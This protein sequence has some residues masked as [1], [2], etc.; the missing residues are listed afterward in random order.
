MGL[1]VLDRTTILQ[2][3]FAHIENRSYEF[4]CH[5]SEPVDRAR[6][7]ACRSQC[8]PGRR[9]HESVAACYEPCIETPPSALPRSFAGASRR[10][11]AADPAGRIA[12]PSRGGRV[13][14]S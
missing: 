4:G 12:A 14:A 8:W 9:A 11:H 2:I 13:G 6:V 7:P 5:G 10:P 3:D 1:T